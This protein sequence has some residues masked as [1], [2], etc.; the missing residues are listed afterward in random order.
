MTIEITNQQK[1]LPVPRTQIAQIKRIV[2]KILRHEG[3]SRAVLSIVFVS[4]PQIRS[5]NKKFLKR[6]YAT[7]VLAFDLSAKG[8]P[9]SGGGDG[10][11]VFLRPKTLE[12]EIVISMGAAIRNAKI[13]KTSPQ[14]EMTLY[15]IHG[16]L[17]LLGYDDHRPVDIR[18]M[19]AKEMKL[20]KLVEKK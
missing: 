20:M 19:R 12:G 1:H 18:R 7:D 14:R 16:I 2:Q 4:D 13:F 9:A 3:V 15:I 17:H 8:G 6:F 10:K 11:R 5:L